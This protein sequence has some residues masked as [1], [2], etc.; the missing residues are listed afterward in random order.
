MFDR[1]FCGIT[2]FIESTVNVL[3]LSSKSKNKS[4]SLISK[5][6]FSAGV[7]TEKEKKESTSEETFQFQL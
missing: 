6:N 5:E 4:T 7:L 2:E 3:L 1:F